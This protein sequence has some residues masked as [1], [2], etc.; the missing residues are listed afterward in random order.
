MI[1]TQHRELPWGLLKK[2]A[3]TMWNQTLRVLSLRILYR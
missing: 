2:G 3:V 1:D